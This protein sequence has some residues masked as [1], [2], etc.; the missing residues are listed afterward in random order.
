MNF[1]IVSTTSQQINQGSG[2]LIRGPRLGIYKE[3]SSVAT[4]WQSTVRTERYQI[5]THREWII[6]TEEKRRLASAIDSL[7]LY[8]SHR[9]RSYLVGG[10]ENARSTWFHV[11]KQ[12][13]PKLAQFLMSS[14]SQVL[15]QSL[16]KP[17]L[18]SRSPYGWILLSVYSFY[19]FFTIW[20]R[21]QPAL[22]DQL[23][24]IIF[25]S[26][27]FESS[28]FFRGFIKRTWCPHW[29]VVPQ[30]SPYSGVAIGGISL[31]VSHDVCEKPM[32]QNAY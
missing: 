23:P 12:W 24:P 26:A 14:R 25:Q 6:R 13:E 28:M 22:W 16:L 27:R 30:N 15:G 20:E 3:Q 19:Q 32:N 10:L 1:L 11:L 2:T 31:H 4:S 17:I 18:W 7:L 9:D 8:R 5:F 21:V 29:R